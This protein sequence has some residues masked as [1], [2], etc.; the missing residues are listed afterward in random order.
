[1]INIILEN[2]K[3]ILENDNIILENDNIILEID[4]YFGN[5]SLF[6]KMITLFCIKLYDH[7]CCPSWLTSV[8]H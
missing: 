5:W 2:D 3:I 6:W 8:L 1:M 4:H 7:L